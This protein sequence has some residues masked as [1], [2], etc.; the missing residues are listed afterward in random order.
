MKWKVPS[1]T[2]VVREYLV[3]GG[4]VCEVGVCRTGIVC[5][6]AIG[7][8]EVCDEHHDIVRIGEA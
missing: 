4:V 3:I 2:S 1:R 6:L 5:I 8:Q 7:E